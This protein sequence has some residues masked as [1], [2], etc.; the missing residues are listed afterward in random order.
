MIPSVPHILKALPLLFPGLCFLAFPI[1]VHP[2]MNRSE[3][4]TLGIAGAALACWMIVVWLGVL[5]LAADGNGDG[6]TRSN[7]RTLIQFVL[8]SIGIG[9]MTIANKL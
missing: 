5:T 2:L 8:F 4:L 7:R 3:P 6:M 9:L 1:A